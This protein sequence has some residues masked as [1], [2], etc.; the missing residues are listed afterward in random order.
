MSAKKKQKNGGQE[1]PGAGAGIE[2]E[3]GALIA[4]LAY[5]KW[6]ARGCPVGDDQ[7]DWFDAE[8]EAR[9]AGPRDLIT[10]DSSRKGA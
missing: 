3:G 7:R 9:A 5:D 2:L 6:Q 4:R 10:D 1:T 8:Q